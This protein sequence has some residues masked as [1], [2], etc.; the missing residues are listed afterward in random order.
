MPEL[1]SP[2]V[3]SLVQP[4]GL[5]FRD[6]TDLSLVTDQLMVRV[7]DKKQPLQKRELEVVPSGYWTTSR[8]AGF[9]GW[10]SDRE[11]IYAVEIEDKAR[12]FLPTR[13]DITIDKTPDAPP[14]PKKPSTV[15]ELNRW[16]DWSSLNAPRTKTLFPAGAKAGYQPDYIPLFPTSSRAAP[17]PRAEVRGHLL[18]AEGATTRPANWA[19]ITVSID[20]IVVGLGIADAKGAVVAAFPYPQ[21]PSPVADQAV[22]GRASVTWSVTVEVFWADLAGEQPDLSAVLGQLA[23]PAMKPLKALL[24]EIPADP[25]PVLGPQVLTL[26]QPL[27]LRTFEKEKADPGKELVPL[28]SLYLKTP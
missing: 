9:G 2:D 17:G 5:K 20:G 21:F 10:P 18:V 19:A 8:L 7:A 23:S 3:I 6:A 14:E 26:G 4:L 25:V 12:R 24:A 13:F 1:R 11:R 16:I 27:I 22:K 28:S 15:G